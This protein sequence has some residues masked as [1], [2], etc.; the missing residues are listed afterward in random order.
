MRLPVE[1]ISFTH[2]VEKMLSFFSQHLNYTEH[3]YVEYTIGLSQVCLG[4][5]VR[6]F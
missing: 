6:F 5:F 3:R 1:S 2:K 4:E